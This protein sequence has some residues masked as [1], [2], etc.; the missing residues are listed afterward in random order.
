MSVDDGRYEDDEVAFLDAIDDEQRAWLHQRGV[1]RT[2]AAGSALF[3]EHERSTRVLVLLSGRVKIASTSEDGRER[4]LAFRGAGEVLGELSAIDGRP[5]SATVTA[6]EPVEALA[7]SAGDFRAFL[8][9]S[10]RVTLYLLG[11]LVARLREADRK[12]AEFGASDTIGRVAA[13]LV[14]LARDYG[15]E[16]P[17][18]GVLIDLPI[19]QE[20]LASWV[21]SSREGVNKA[22]HTLRSLGWVDVERR[23]FTVLDL[24]ALQ[25][26]SA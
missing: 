7:V 18:G 1:V 21:G 24:D 15:R 13:R 3:L 8:E 14:E 4:V 16:Q 5:R 25:R 2:F 12:R 23:Q 17:G 10:P 26:R 11:K 6:I 9:D 19:T 20:E 22:L